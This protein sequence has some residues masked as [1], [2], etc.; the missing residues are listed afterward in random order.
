MLG[1]AITSVP[2]V[3][4]DPISDKRAQ[5]A[6]LS[7]ELDRLNT[8]QEQLAE[9]FNGA[10]VAADRVQAEVVEANAAVA[11]ANVALGKQRAELR[12]VAVTT[13]VDGGTHTATNTA[14]IDSVAVSRFYV[15]AINSRQ[16]D[17][18]DALE[19]A[20]TD[21]QAE[22]ARLHDAQARAKDAVDAV[23]K[24]R[25]AASAAAVQQQ[26]AL[27]KAQ[28]EL[29]TLV[30]EDEARKAAAEAARVKAELE[31]QQELAAAQAASRARAIA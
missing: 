4:A 31:R 28:G 2:G 10:R 15:S 24:D 20:K 29:A 8:K 18:L 22:Q 3:A 26:V 17:V 30:A 16:R 19:Q 23:A 27:S 11:K 21:Y 14:A 5:A 7:S 12:D 13:Y 25:Q 1:M 6:Q 9:K